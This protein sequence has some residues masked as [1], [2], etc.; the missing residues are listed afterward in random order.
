MNSYFETNVSTCDPLEL[1]RLLFRGAIDSLR[2]ART[3]MRAGDIQERSKQV[4]RCQQIVAE[5]ASS[6]RPEHHPELVLSLAQLYEYVLHLTQW[7]N[8]HQKE[9][10]LSEAQCLLETLLAGWQDC[11]VSAQLISSAA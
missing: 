8:F 4:A 7:G 1:T 5:L 11:D 2:K 3:A 10:P 6:L 9:E